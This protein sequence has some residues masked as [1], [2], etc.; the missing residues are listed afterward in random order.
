MS[1][2]WS[3]TPRQTDWLTV[4]RNGTLTLSA[5]CYTRMRTRIV[6]EEYY[7]VCQHSAPFIVN[8]P[9]RLF[10]CF[11]QASRFWLYCASL[12]HEFHTSTPFLSQKTVAIS[13]LAG[14]QRLFK[15]FRLAWW[16][17]VH[18]L[19]WLHFGF[20]IHKWKPYFIICHSY[21]DIEKFIA[22]FVVSL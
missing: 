6:M 18:P 14:R 17:C 11:S 21:D 2:R 9:T 1:P 4:S 19:L 3:S 12:L 8:G 10:S 16:V 13:F 5:S 22:I 7:T 15:P 20:S